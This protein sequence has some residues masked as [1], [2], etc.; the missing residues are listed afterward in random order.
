MGALAANSWPSTHSQLQ[1]NTR[2]PPKPIISAEPLQQ[3]R[4]QDRKIE[5]ISRAENSL[6]HKQSGRHQWPRLQLRSSS[7]APDQ[8]RDPTSPMQ[9]LSEICCHAE[10]L[11]IAASGHDEIMR[12]LTRSNEVAAASGRETGLPLGVFGSISR[13]GL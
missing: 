11:Q 13:P 9:A 4:G 8:S 1:P 2:Q 10:S 6:F 3:A 12:R 7:R 5:N